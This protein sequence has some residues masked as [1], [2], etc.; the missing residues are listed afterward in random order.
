MLAMVASVVLIV[1]RRLDLMR[2]HR[3]SHHCCALAITALV[4]LGGCDDSAPSVPGGAQTGPTTPSGPS[5]PPGPATP[6]APNTPSGP[7][8]LQGPDQYLEDPAVRG[9]IDRSGF[10]VH[11]GTNPPP[12]SGAY[13]VSGRVVSAAASYEYL[14]S[15][16]LRSEIRMF[17]QTAAGRINMSEEFLGTQVSG[18]GG[19]ITGSGGTFTVWQTAVEDVVELT[20]RIE[21]T[22]RWPSQGK[23]VAT[24]ALLMSGRRADD[25][26]LLNVQGLTAA[27][28]LECPAAGQLSDQLTQRWVGSWYKWEAAFRRQS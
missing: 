5:T 24:V 27:V 10:P 8:G 28:D 13:R 14:L 19:Y 6:P 22:F 11:R 16:L 17:N 12:L 18:T 7:N 26:D 20:R 25:G 21:P 23:C 2:R 4:V 9:A 3:S 15:Y 1:L